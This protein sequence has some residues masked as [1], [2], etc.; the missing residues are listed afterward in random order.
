MLRSLVTPQVTQEDIANKLGVTQQAVSAWVH[1]GSRPS[2]ERMMLLERLFGIPIQ[3]WAEDAED[4]EEKAP[5]SP[6]QGAA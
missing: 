1:G 4:A 6:P 5:D 3:S 2:L